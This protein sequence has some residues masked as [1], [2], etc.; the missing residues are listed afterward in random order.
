ML[1]FEDVHFQLIDIPP[2]SP[3]HP[4]SWIGNALQPSDGGLVVVDLNEPDCLDQVNAVI[5][6]L[7]GRRI[8]LLEKWGGRH[9][10][11]R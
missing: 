4:L 9:P 5:D 1:A 7:N 10:E 2:L 3:E 6:Q 8:T 11:P